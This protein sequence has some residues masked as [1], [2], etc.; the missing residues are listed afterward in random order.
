M[1]STAVYDAASALGY[2]LNTSS[3]AAQP[4]SL[5]A[6]SAP[7]QARL[8][9]AYHAPSTSK[10]TTA[11]LIVTTGT[12]RPLKTVY[13]P[14]RA[15]RRQ[16]VC[17]QADD[18]KVSRGA[19]SSSTTPRSNAWHQNAR[20]PAWSGRALRA[21]GRGVSDAHEPARTSMGAGVCA[22]PSW[23]RLKAQGAPAAERRRFFAIYEL[24]AGATIEL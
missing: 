23:P 21:R 9:A 1:G 13:A 8:R 6:A 24:K 19:P 3:H 12:R 5:Y 10:F 17:I 20:P 15:S 4:P 22:G 7:S 16:P 11:S 18:D 2:E 14:I